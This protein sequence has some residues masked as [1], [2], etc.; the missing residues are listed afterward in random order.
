M[1]PRQLKYFLRIARL[2]SFT[3]AAAVLHVAQPALS[4]QIQQLEA[5]LGVQLFVRSDTGVALTDAGEALTERAAKLLEHFATVRD[6]IG[7]LSGQ[8]QGRLTFGIPPSLHEPL[9]VPTL[10]AYRSLHPA[11]ALSAVEGISATVYEMVL[12]GRLDIGIV[13]STE[14]MHGLQQRPLFRERLFLAGAPEH[15]SPAATVS[16]Q[17]VAEH[18][19]V[20]TQRPN[21]MRMVLEDALRAADLSCRCLLE[22]NST[23]VQTAMAAAGVGCTVLPYG[24]IAE[25]VDAGR[26]VASPIESLDITWTLI[27]SKDRA[28][29]TAAQRLIELLLQQAGQRAADGRWPGFAA[30]K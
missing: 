20:L 12:G 26:L 14:S 6:E 7:G 5:D 11:V 17:A 9:T 15:L 18:P 22:A 16:L 1:T 23:R 13:L 30:L 25:D 4:R 8:V 21:A 24:A 10:L 2:R 19:L 29:S 28:L 27:H 3:K